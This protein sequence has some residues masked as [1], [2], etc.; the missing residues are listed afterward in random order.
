MNT[1]A[2]V[3][4]ALKKLENSLISKHIEADVDT[5][6]WFLYSITQIMIDK[7]NGQTRNAIEHREETCFLIISPSFLI[8]K[9]SRL[10]TSKLNIKRRLVHL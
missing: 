10:N 4:G 1:K 7:T 5:L 6:D 2:I 8:D 3:G 9:D